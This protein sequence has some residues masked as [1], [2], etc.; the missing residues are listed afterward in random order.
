[1]DQSILGI[2]AVFVLAIVAGV[3]YYRKHTQ[4]MVVGPVLSDNDS[5]PD[6]DLQHINTLFMAVESDASQDGANSIR[7]WESRADLDDFN[8]G[9][10]EVP[11][12]ELPTA[13]KVGQHITSGP[14]VYDVADDGPPSPTCEQ[15][16]PPVYDLANDSPLPDPPGPQPDVAIYDNIDESCDITDDPYTQR[17]TM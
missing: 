14:H 3:L 6:S 11:Q 10:Y 15:H 12:L 13:A 8:E 2:L 4:R 9:M 7:R 5:G 16:G 1:M 17:T